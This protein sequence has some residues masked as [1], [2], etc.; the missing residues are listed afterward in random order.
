MIELLVVISIISTL[1]SM[2]LAS[3]NSAREKG[4]IAG[5]ILFSDNLYH[6][7]GAEATSMWDFNEQ[8]LGAFVPD[9]GANNNLIPSAGPPAV[10]PGIIGNG[11]LFNG[12]NYLTSSKPVSLGLD[13]TI[14]AW[15]KPE[16]GNGTMQTI[17]SL[18]GIPS[19]VYT[20]GLGFGGTW[21]YNPGFAETLW[22]GKRSPNMWYYIALTHNNTNNNTVLYVDGREVG[23]DTER[24][25]VAVSSTVCVGSHWTL[26]N[27]CNSYTF[28]GII[29]DVKVY[30]QS[31]ASKDIERLYAKA[32]TKYNIAVR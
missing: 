1:S 11:L 17:V 22:S 31:L 10:V 4:R 26:P 21:N 27:N 14:A 16:L 3:L 29:D 5:G 9:T 13:W 18:G 15:V 32:I 25:S 2:I 8:T 28:Y 24:D 20:G 12:S 30:S 23:R 7:Y 19:I 6:S